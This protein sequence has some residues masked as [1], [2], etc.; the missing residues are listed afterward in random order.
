VLAAI[1]VAF[2]AL[3]L[4]GLLW[5]APWSSA[6]S[7]LTDDTRSPRCGCRWCSL[8]ATVLSMVFGVPLAWLLARVDFPGRALVR[9]L[10]LLSMVLPPVVG[11][12]ALFFALGRRGLVGQYL[13]EWF[14]ITL[15]FTTA[16]VVV[17][18]T[19]VAMPFLVI[20]VEAA[21]RQLD[22]ASRTRRGRSARRVVHVPPGDAAGDPPGAGGRRRARL[23]SGARRVRRHDHL[24]RQ[25]PGH[26]PDD[27]AGGVPVARDQ[28]EEAIVLALVLIAISFAVL[29]GAA[30]AV[31]RS[32]R[33][34][35]TA[36][37]PRDARRP[38][39]TAAGAR[40]IST[41]SCRRSR[42]R[43]S[44]CSA[45]TAPARARCCAA[46][47]AWNPSTSGRI[48][49]D[50]VVVDDPVADVFV[51]PEDA[52]IGV[53][54]QDYLLFDH[55]SVLENVAYGLRA[56]G[57][58]Q[59]P[60]RAGAP[61]SGWNVST[62][63]STPSTPR[64]A[65]GR[66][67]AARGARPG[68]RHRPAAAAARRTARRARRRDAREVR[69]D[70]RRHLA[71]FDGMRVLV[72]HDPVDAHASPTGWWCSTPAASCRRARWPR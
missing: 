22:R 39:R 52:P 18:Q 62:S 14:G 12:V 6:W 36:P 7:Y 44:P 59:T 67:G 38:H 15:P 72:T 33:P 5:R 9:A 47:P 8:W 17:A 68:A 42:A 71:T 21:L 13:D 53:V 61:T 2:F 56:R 19:F 28:P 16:G 23:G 30:R 50:G 45:R 27:A 58:G 70:L 37:V 4:V 29:V 35:G 43:W 26:H 49:I 1:A 60:R 69:R 24:R 55:M 57:L 3:P 41:W 40:S 64:G 34:S 51:E 31:V 10:C 65:V 46:S 48:T 66:P 32:D 20:T 63:P 25:L 54:F 11:G